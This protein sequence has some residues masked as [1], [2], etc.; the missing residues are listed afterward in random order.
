MKTLLAVGLFSLGLNAFATDALTL[1]VEVYRFEG[2]PGLLKGKSSEDQLTLIADRRPVISQKL[3]LQPG[4]PAKSSTRIDAFTLGMDVRL[5][6]AKSAAAMLHVNFSLSEDVPVG[7]V[8]T[9]VTQTVNTK[10]SLKPGQPAVMGSA[11]LSS[12]NGVAD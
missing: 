2:E 3:E 4:V 12:A 5:E 9:P 1:I 10:L 11:P 6:P 8:V 7:A